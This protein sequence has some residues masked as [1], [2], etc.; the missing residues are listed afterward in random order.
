MSFLCFY[1][2]IFVG[3]SDLVVRILVG[4]LEE[5]LGLRERRG[6]LTPTLSL[7]TGRGSKKKWGI[8]CRMPLEPRDT[9]LLT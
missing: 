9:K 4:Q 1:R 7:S 5:L 6:T 8:L 3:F 2:F